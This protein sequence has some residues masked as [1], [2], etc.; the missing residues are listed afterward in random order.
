VTRI[1]VFWSLIHLLQQPNAAGI[2]S[3]DKHGNI[4]PSNAA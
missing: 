1:D 2:D 3:S 4:I